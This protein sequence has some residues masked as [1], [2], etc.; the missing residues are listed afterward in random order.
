MSISE[1]ITK[2][3]EICDLCGMVI[4]ITNTGN[5][6]ICVYCLEYEDE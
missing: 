5:S 1:R 4:T 6:G 3:Y 2:M